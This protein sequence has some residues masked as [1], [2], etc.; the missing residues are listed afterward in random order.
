VLGRYPAFISEYRSAE[1]VMMRCEDVAA[2][3]ACEPSRVK[4]FFRVFVVSRLQVPSIHDILSLVHMKDRIAELT[5]SRKRL[6][7]Q[8]PDSSTIL[9]GSLLSRMIRC[10]KP[11]CRFC[12]KGK[13]KGHGPIWILSVSLGNRKVRQ[14]P[15]PLE[16]KPEVE[17]GLRTFAQL[18]ERL[19]QIAQVNLE[20]LEERK[21]RR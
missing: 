12:E 21:R 15:I 4:T 18:Q 19:K 3:A 20:L 2:C 16:L 13:G 8:L 17:E 9:P 5:A 10:N 14:I 11:G 7:Q 1:A 6:L